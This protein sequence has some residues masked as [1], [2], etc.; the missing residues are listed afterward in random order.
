ITVNYA[1]KLARVTFRAA[2]LNVDKLLDLGIL[3]ETTGQRRNRIYTAP[4]VLQ[5]YDK[6]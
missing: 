4:D 3:K 1:S 6:R 2:Q 5:I